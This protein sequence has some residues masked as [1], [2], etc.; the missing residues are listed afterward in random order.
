M[1]RIAGLALLA[2]IVLFVVTQMIMPSL[3]GRPWWPLFR[4]RPLE[5]IDQEILDAQDQIELKKR[6]DEADKLK[7]KAAAN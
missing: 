6:R 1:M 5:E 2:I 4:K 3:Q 7:K